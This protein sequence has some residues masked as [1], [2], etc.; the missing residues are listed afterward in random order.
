MFRPHAL[1]LLLALVLA[2][3]TGAAPPQ[4]HRCLG[5]TATI[6]GTPGDDVLVGTP[7]RDVI[8]GL[9]G[10]DR[11]E[12]GGGFDRLCGGDEEDTLSFV[13]ARSGVFASLALGLSIGGGVSTFAGFEHLLG[14]AAADVLRGDGGANIIEG[15]DGDDHLF[16]GGGNDLAS[17]ASFGGMAGSSGLIGVGVDLA[18]GTAQGAGSD[19]LVSFEHVLGSRFADVLS[20]DDGPNVLRGAD[21]DDSLQ[22]RGGND[23]L[24]GGE[25]HDGLSGDGGDD[26]IDGGPG[27][28]TAGFG[29]A[30]AGVQVDLAAGTATGDGAD[31]LM[32][33]Q[34]LAG[35]PHDDELL[36][37]DEANAIYGHGG[38]DAISGRG[39]NDFLY[40]EA[41][42]GWFVGTPGKDL[43]EGGA[44]D[45]FLDGGAGVLDFASYV[46][47]PGPMDVS[48]EAG[49]ATGEGSDQL[50]GIEGVQGG[51]FNDSIVG[52]SGDNVLR[53]Q[54][55]NDQLFGLGGRD[56]LWGDDG[57]DLLDGGDEV[58]E[59]STGE[60]LLNCP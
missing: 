51:R 48:L 44:G 5:A 14:S 30:P 15:G 60:T 31:T 55:G 13:G 29:E 45:D 12:G 23:G 33:V 9:G 21:G 34:H 32:S 26:F 36:G 54:G 3:P 2:A 47:A 16:G 46:A 4:Q 8:V 17:Y 22:G 40:G 58:D 50:H 43:I 57:F 19:T 38:D 59:C 1:I 37:N 52:H 10:N 25:G 28:D 56:R 27:I 39:G 24:G 41:T 7:S 18:R 11:I 42:E 35:S 53:G 49:S 6:V 20:G